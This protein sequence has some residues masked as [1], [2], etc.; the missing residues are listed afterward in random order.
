MASIMKLI[1]KIGIDVA[2]KIVK[3]PA[4]CCTFEY[5]SKTT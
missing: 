1:D 2:R 3:Q 5:D 4:L